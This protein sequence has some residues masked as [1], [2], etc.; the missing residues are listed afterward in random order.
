[1]KNKKG[2]FFELLSGIDEDLL[3]VALARRYAL[4]HG[5][6]VA[7]R[8][9]WQRVAAL[10]AAVLLVLAGVLSTVLA[11]RADGYY[12][13]EATLVS[14]EV[15]TDVYTLTYRDGTHGRFTLRAPLSPFAYCDGDGAVDAAITAGRVYAERGDLYLAYA[16]GAPISLGGLVGEREAG[17]NHPADLVGITLREGV[18]E[19]A[20]ANRESIRLDMPTEGVFALSAIRPNRKGHMRL[21][22]AGGA[23]VALGLVATEQGVLTSGVSVSETGEMSLTTKTGEQLPIGTLK[24][25]GRQS[26]YDLYRETYETEL[27]P[28]RW[29]EEVT[30]SEQTEIFRYNEHGVIVGLTDY[31]KTREN[32]IIPTGVTAIGEE[33]LAHSAA[34]RSVTLPDSVTDI[35]MHA[36]ANCPLLSSV[37]LGEGVE[38]ISMGAFE[39]CY[40]L[41]SIYLPQSLREVEDFLFSGCT[42]LLQI[43]LAPRES[44]DNWAELALAGCEKLVEVIVPE[45]VSWR[46]LEM[47]SCAVH[48][49]ETSLLSVDEDGFVFAASF[50]GNNTPH[51]V[52]YVG[53]GPIP[54]LP[55]DHLG[56]AY[57]IAPYA[58]AHR[59][60]LTELRLPAGV[61]SVG[62]Y[63]FMD[64]GVRTPDLSAVTADFGMGV[65]MGCQELTEVILPK[66]MTEVP[67]STFASCAR[68]TNVTFPDV[69]EV[70]GPYAFGNCYA[71]E[72]ALLPDSVHTIGAEA[73]FVCTALSEV[74]MDGVM[75]I[76]EDAFR[77]CNSLQTLRLPDTLRHIGS[78]AFYGCGMTSLVIPNGVTAIGFAALDGCH[79]LV[80]LTLP[81]IGCIETENGQ[82]DGVTS[83]AYLGALFGAVTP[84]K[85]WD[86][87]PDALRRVRVEAG[88]IP[89]RAFYGCDS[90]FAVE[91]GE[92]VGSIGDYAFFGCTA[93]SQVTFE[94]TATIS[95]ADTIG[96]WAFGECASLPMLT[97]PEGYVSIV[98]AAFGGCRALESITLPASLTTIGKNAFADSLLLT[99]RTYA[100]APAPGWSDGWCPENT[101]ILYLG[102]W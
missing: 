16:D 65:F 37:D 63:A 73:F 70:I 10:A 11:T 75:E 36:F 25:S 56:A 39:G 62:G 26:A 69:L 31:G 96:I 49:G 14:S 80:S 84:E 3:S 97:L 64:T 51:L 20:L 4:M 94:A 58:L 82:A 42:A 60:E 28:D 57:H 47:L 88:D 48:H 86:S 102:Q 61:L 90:L 21:T 27:D 59:A 100:P 95:G 66:M 2:F 50:G 24:E 52:D 74:R 8:I 99:V 7:R 45:G 34:L 55:A 93:L 40:S 17:D 9:P 71:L 1:M 46:G 78:A 33:A 41:R 77:A 19:V 44:Y 89:V 23:R 98:G 15:G 67:H 5:A 83:F 12:V 35:G 54:A 72:K 22:L 101:Q 13:K 79:S 30:L 81:T 76:G 68:L 38:R 18:L 32:L 43:T 53:D 87:L 85:Q 91:L 29:L 6:P 92:A